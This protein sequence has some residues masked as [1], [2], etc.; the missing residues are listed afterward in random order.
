MKTSTLIKVQRFFFGHHYTSEVW[1]KKF[2]S[3]LILFF[4]HHN[5]LAYVYIQVYTLKIDMHIQITHTLKKLKLKKNDCIENFWNWIFFWHMKLLW[6]EWKLM[7]KNFSYILKRIMKKMYI[8]RTIQT[9]FVA[10][11]FFTYK[12]LIIIINNIKGYIKNL[13]T[14]LNIQKNLFC[15]EINVWSAKSSLCFTIRCT[16]SLKLT[17]KKKITTSSP[18]KL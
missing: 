10:Y 18:H 7:Y 11:I 13:S 3:F 15:W 8:M 9:K 14:T 16:T 1:L 2:I 17:I 5:Q 12:L 4:K 6:V